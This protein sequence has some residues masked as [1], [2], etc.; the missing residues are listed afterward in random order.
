MGAVW[1]SGIEWPLPCYPVLL[2]SD[3]RPAKHNAVCKNHF[4]HVTCA[5]AGGHPRLAIPP[6]TPPA[7][8]QG[9]GA[10]PALSLR[11]PAFT[12][13]LT[14]GAARPRPPAPAKQPLAGIRS[15]AEALLGG[16]G[17]RK[18]RTHQ[19]VRMAHQLLGFTLPLLL[20]FPPASALRFSAVF[21]RSGALCRLVDPLSA[22][23]N[24]Y[25]R[26]TCW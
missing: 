13:T 5:Q 24:P 12:F 21:A 2:A 4:A 3:T 9:K 10:S 16:Q 7:A 15:L 25:W 19:S 1:R 17:R 26:S 18:S 20:A 11:Q 23:S 14:L 6:R 8:F 22:R